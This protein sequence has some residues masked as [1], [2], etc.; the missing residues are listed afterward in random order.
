MG[1]QVVSELNAEHSTK[2]QAVLQI[3]QNGIM[4]G[5]HVTR[6]PLRTLRSSLSQCSFSLNPSEE[7]TTSWFLLRLTSGLTQ[8]TRTWCQLT[9]TSDTSPRRSLMPIQVSSHGS[10]SS[11]NTP[12]CKIIPNSK[13]THTDGHPAATHLIRDHTIALLVAMFASEEQLLML[14]K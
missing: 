4:M 8:P 6:L 9:Q 7:E 2:N 10:E 1:V 13:L 5:P 11:R 12:S 14:T 3:Y